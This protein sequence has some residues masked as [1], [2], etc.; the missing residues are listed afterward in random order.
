MPI[1]PASTSGG[2]SSGS[3]GSISTL[4]GTAGEDISQY[5]VV[6]YTSSG[7]YK[8]SKN[9]GTEA[10]AD[11]VGIATANIPN[12]S[13][14]N[15]Q[16]GLGTVTNANWEFTPGDQLYVSDTYGEITN[17]VPSVIGSY[18]KP[19]GYATSATTIV[20]FPG[21][22]WVVGGLSKHGSSHYPDSTDPIE[23]NIDAIGGRLD[24]VSATSLKWGFQNSNQLKLFNPTTSKWELVRASTEPTIANT[25]ND[26]NGTALAPNTI[27]D[28][29]AEYNSS[30][31]MNLV[32]SRWA[33]GGDGANNSSTSYA[34]PVMT[35][36]T[37]PGPVAVS[38]DTEYDTNYK[39]YRAFN[40]ADGSYD[41]MATNTSHPHMLMVDF[42]QPVCI[43][44][45]NFRGRSQ[46]ANAWTPADFVVQGTNNTSAAAS[47]AKNAN[48]WV[49]LDT[50][51]GVA[52]PG[53]SSW[54]SN[55]LTFN[56][57]LSYRY[58]R[59]YITKNSANNN[60]TNLG[61]L[62][63]VAAANSL[64]GGSSR[65]RAYESTVTYAIGD[66]VTNGGHD[67]VKT[68]TAAAGTTPAAGS[69][70]VDNGTSISGDFAGLYRHDGVLV[71]S[72]STTGK[73]RRWLGIIYTYNNS[74]TVNFK[75]DVN[76]R[77]ISNF[78]NTT[79][80]SC[81]AYSNS[82]SYTFSA[83]S[84]TEMSNAIRGRCVLCK[85][86][87]TII[88]MIVN[89]VSPSS[90]GTLWE[91]I[92]LNTTDKALAYNQIFSAVTSCSASASS[93]IACGYNYITRYDEGNNTNQSTIYGDTGKKDNTSMIIMQ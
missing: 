46:D 39:A 28:V 16:I 93:D 41:W 70:W 79:L 17:I 92:Y 3:G 21:E 33:T 30:T 68:S 81:N 34:T 54:L 22:G 67:W 76:Y 52:S 91:H 55:Y 82:S 57:S 37:A 43:N 64:A 20:F 24:L 78:Y 15:I 31:S 1:I 38:A 80:K 83:Q 69:D 84:L 53:Q 51:T 90:G 2:G 12:A 85:S 23:V 56:N 8:K 49:D 66:R 18:V 11:C 45:Y 32:L 72:S 44:K 59:L 71:S 87:S 6:Y 88:T 5:D 86:Q 60:M 73:S 62:K 10:E 75:D 36:N 61:E 40:Q 47:D 9:N 50:R 74:G 48:G 26:L 27:Y 89:C 14:G 63:L 25:A 35:S 7:T 58:Y 29:F 77:Y 4:L 65:V 19:V 13:T 42:G